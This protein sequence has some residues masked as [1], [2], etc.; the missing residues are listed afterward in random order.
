MLPSPPST[1]SWWLHR[2]IMFD[3]QICTLTK[4]VYEKVKLSCHYL[5]LNQCR[6]YYTFSANKYEQYMLTM[7]IKHHYFLVWILGTKLCDNKHWVVFA[8]L[9]GLRSRRFVLFFFEVLY[10]SSQCSNNADQQEYD[11]T[12]NC[13]HY[14]EHHGSIGFYSTNSKIS[15]K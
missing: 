5:A 9:C 12:K 13:N 2:Y 7:A 4:I 1:L 6:L 10:L 3:I 15:D 8:I 11:Q 14:P